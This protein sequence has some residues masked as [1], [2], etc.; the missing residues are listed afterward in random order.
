[1]P[2]VGVHMLWHMAVW[3]ALI[4]VCAVKY[5]QLWDDPQV[6][7][8]KS[9]I[10]EDPRHACRSHGC[11]WEEQRGSSVTLNSSLGIEIA[12]TDLGNTWLGTSGSLWGL[13]S[14]SC[15]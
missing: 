3:L 9:I 14:G 1:M 12:I 2:W 15:Q 4:A 13:I 8:A 11:L 7:I 10:C 6:E 5:F